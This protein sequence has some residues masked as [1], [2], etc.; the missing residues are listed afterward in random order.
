MRGKRSISML[1]ALVL[2]LA[3]QVPSLAMAMDD[4][5]AKGSKY[6]Q[7]I[8]E[9][10]NKTLSTN[11]EFKDVRGKVEDE[12]ITLTGSVNLV[13]DKM[14]LDRKM[15]D[16]EH[17]QSIRNYVRIASP[18]VSD[19]ELRDK[20]ADKLRYDR[21]GYGI[22][23]NAINLGVK[24]GIVTLKGSV[25]DEP[26]RASALAIVENTPGVKGV[27]ED[28]D[29]QPASPFDDDLRIRLSRKIY[30]DPALQ[31][32]WLDPQKP[33]RIVVDR[34]H[35]TLYG[36]VDNKMDKQ[37]AEMRAREVP[38]V[39]SVDDKLVIAGQEAR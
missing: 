10:V 35:V 2:S 29:V 3:F 5:G 16:K 27:V 15:H 36:V 20:L 30:G 18:S 11:K 13:A 8:Q 19:A 24:D 1:L 34:G 38:N 26:S 33:I 6:D 28:L 23:F 21:A 9:S 22:A 25:L 14:K 32:Y 7:E 12:V 31:K 17:V 4:Q 37:I 39:F